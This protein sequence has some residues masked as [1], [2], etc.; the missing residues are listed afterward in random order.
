[1][2]DTYEPIGIIS[3]LDGV[4]ESL[5]HDFVFKETRVENSFTFYHGFINNRRVIM[6][7]CAAGKI[8]AA[9]C[10]TLLIRTFA[11]KSCILV[12]TAG[13]LL[14]KQKC[15][16]LVLAR[17]VV[18]HDMDATR[19]GYPPGTVPGLNLRAIPCDKNLLEFAFASC[20]VLLGVKAESGRILTGDQFITHPQRI[21][22]LQTLYNGACVDM[23]SFAVAQTCCLMAVPF[24]VI[25][26]I[27]E[28]TNGKFVRQYAVFAQLAAVNLARFLRE[29]I[30]QYPAFPF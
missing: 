2:F 26:T 23:E 24:G 18:C 22:Y 8:N 15:G 10:T 12:G 6:V 9:I 25:R 17:D 27:A 28:R 13:G 14:H 29:M 5:L 11:I 16:D 4:I 30:N 21:T 1:M 7:R 20:P 3:T 19:L